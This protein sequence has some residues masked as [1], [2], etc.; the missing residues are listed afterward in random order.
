MANQLLLCPRPISFAPGKPVFCT[1]LM[2]DQPTLDSFIGP[3]SWILFHKL[4][5]AGTWLNRE[6]MEWPEDD[7]YKRLETFLKDL[8]VVN[9]LA[10]RCVG[11]VQT[12]RNMAK[13]SVHRDEILLVA[14]DHRGVFQD[15][16]KQA[17]Q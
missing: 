10:E 16:R 14:S 5:A 8:K 3:R 4:N 1:D 15:L 2:T 12:Y 6:V 11:A 17:L 9:D 7:E 13:D